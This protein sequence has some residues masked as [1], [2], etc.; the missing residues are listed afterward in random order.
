VT[1][2]ATG[3]TAVGDLVYGTGIVPGTYVVS[4]ITNTSITLSLPVTG[5]GAQTLTLTGGAFTAVF[6]GSPNATNANYTSINVVPKTVTSLQGVV[7]QTNT[8]GLWTYTV[9]TGQNYVRIRLSSITNMSNGINCWIDSYSVNKSIH[10]PYVTGLTAALFNTNATALAFIP[11]IDCSD[12]T[13]IRVDLTAFTGTANTL[14]WQQSSDPNLTTPQ[15]LSA[16]LTNASPWTVATSNSGAGVYRMVPHTQYFYAKLTGTA[17]TAFN[18][19]AVTASIGP[20]TQQDTTQLIANASVNIGQLT[21]T[22][23][24][25]TVANGSANKSLSVYTAGAVANTDYSAVAWA[26]ASGAGATI[27]IDP[28]SAVAYDI[29]VTALS[30]GSSTGLEIY[31]DWSPDSG[32]TWYHY[33]ETEAITAV[34]HYWIPPL[35]VPGRRRLSWIQV[36]NVAAITTTVTVTAQQVSFNPPVVHQYFDR[37]ATLLSGTLSAASAAYD[38]SGCFNI[39]ARVVLG[40]ATTPGTYQ[41]QVSDDSISWASVGTATAAVANSTINL[42]ASN[43]VARFARVIVTSGATA[44]T[45]TYVSIAAT[46]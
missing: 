8:Y 18:C 7:N 43:I 15:V 30:P 24:A 28:G 19:G 33:Y 36:N 21:G 20:L 39:N 31:A 29:N 3:A 23:A 46:Q 2:A 38:V 12:F 17:F 25:A 42:T 34:G 11:P 26:A 9:P 27:A 10:L 4:V 44:Q 35:Q 6:E 1:A 40:A 16:Y 32:T 37:T 41:I 5:A 45:G 13:S 22:T 14:T